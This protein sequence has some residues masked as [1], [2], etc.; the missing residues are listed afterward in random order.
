MAGY[1]NVDSK[2]A[3]YFKPK[4]PRATIMLG[5]PGSGK[6]SWL[7]ENRPDSRTC[8]ADYFFTA[9]DGTYEWNREQIGEAHQQCM[10]EWIRLLTDGQEGDIA[11]DNTNTV[12]QTVASYITTAAA[13]GY[14]VEVIAMTSPTI[15]ECVERGL[16]GV[17]KKA[18]RNMAEQ[19]M[20][21][22]THWPNHWPEV[23]YI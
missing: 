8:S 19:L 13:F 15:D 6:T 11:V 20:E 2:H 10:R 3:K 18:T 16:H 7:K 5:I 4:V 22:I 9:E 21:T 23:T 17:G 12:S 1:G 14:R